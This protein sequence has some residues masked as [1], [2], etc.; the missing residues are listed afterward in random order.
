MQPE[1]VQVLQGGEVYY[2]LTA[3]PLLAGEA[4]LVGL[5]PVL[6]DRTPETDVPENNL[7][8]LLLLDN[9]KLAV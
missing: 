3:A 6:D 5:A 2:Y 1:L 4:D 8:S 7:V 9:Q